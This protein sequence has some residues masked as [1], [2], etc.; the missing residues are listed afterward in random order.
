MR[1][2]PVKWR[3]ALPRAWNWAQAWAR[4]WDWAREWAR[5]GDWDG[6]CRSQLGN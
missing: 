2:E 6:K 4:A 3:W 1:L 5:E